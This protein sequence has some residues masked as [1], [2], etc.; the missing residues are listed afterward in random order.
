GLPALKRALGLAPGVHRCQEEEFRTLDQRA[1][2]ARGRVRHDDLS[3]TVCQPSRVKQGLKVPRTV[4]IEIGHDTL[5]L[6]TMTRFITESK[7]CSDVSRQ[8]AIPLA[9]GARR[10]SSRSILG[11][12]TRSSQALA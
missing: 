11:T 6:P 8:A 7:Y 10:V 4:A 3:C 2:I 12:M 5:A 9:I 1:I